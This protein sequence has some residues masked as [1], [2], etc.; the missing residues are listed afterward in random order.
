[1]ICS[2]TGFILLLEFVIM[3]YLGTPVDILLDCYYEDDEDDLES[4]LFIF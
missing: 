3:L 4:D 1:M 2:L